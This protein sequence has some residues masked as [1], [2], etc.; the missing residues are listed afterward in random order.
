[1]DKEYTIFE[2]VIF[3]IGIIALAYFCNGNVLNLIIY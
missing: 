1:M 3:I 2:Q